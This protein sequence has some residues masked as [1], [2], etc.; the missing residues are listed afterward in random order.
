MNKTVKSTVKEGETNAAKQAQKGAENSENK[1]KGEGQPKNDSPTVNQGTPTARLLGGADIQLTNQNGSDKQPS[2]QLNALYA[3][4][5]NSFQKAYALEDARIA[6]A[7]DS[8]VDLAN[9][10]T[11]QKATKTDGT[12]N[13]NADKSTPTTEAQ[14]GLSE[15]VRTGQVEQPN[16]NKTVEERLGLSNPD[17]RLAEELREAKISG[18][19]GTDGNTDEGDMGAGSKSDKQ[20]EARSEAKDPR[21]DDITFLMAHK[22]HRN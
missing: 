7:Q 9:N 1:Q 10:I 17:D 4:P 5:T 13:V 8:L 22:K 20:A 2:N 19:L 3:P 18:T 11:D 21:T 14:L 6:D 16:L 15:E 12:A